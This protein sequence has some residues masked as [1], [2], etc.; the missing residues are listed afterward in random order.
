M[1]PSSNLTFNFSGVKPKGRFPALGERIMVTWIKWTRSRL[2]A[3]GNPNKV[4]DV[5]ETSIKFQQQVRNLGTKTCFF[6]VSF[7]V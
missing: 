7:V 5:L 6:T 2:D 3:V 4:C 1:E